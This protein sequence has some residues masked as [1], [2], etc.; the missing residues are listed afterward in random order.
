M[1]SLNIDPTSQPRWLT[2]EEL[3]EIHTLINTTNLNKLPYGYSYNGYQ[4]PLD[5]QSKSCF[6]TVILTT[7]KN[8]ALHDHLSDFPYAYERTTVPWSQLSPVTQQ[9]YREHGIPYLEEQKII[10]HIQETTITLYLDHLKFLIDAGHVILFEMFFESIPTYFLSFQ[11]VVKLLHGI[12]FNQCYSLR[13]HL[14]R[15]SEMRKTAKS[16]LH[17]KIYKLMM[18]SLF[19]QSS[20]CHSLCLSHIQHLFLPGKFCENPE[21]R[22]NVSVIQRP[23]SMHHIMDISRAQSIDIVGENLVLLHQTKPHVYVESSILAA[24]ILLSVSKLYV[25]GLWE[26]IQTA[27]I[28]PRAVYTDTGT[29]NFV[30]TPYS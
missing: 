25:C 30:L 13:P 15:L 17:Q 7:P 6:V 20:Q 28:R 14:T 1:V 10:T 4:Y 11:T 12:V 26:R 18:N 9:Y 19:G 22:K 5:F 2:T 8:L 23:S 16:P 21:K 27:F 29:Y 3:K 24:T